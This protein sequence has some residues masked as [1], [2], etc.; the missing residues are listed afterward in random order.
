MISVP[1]E[2]EYVEFGTLIPDIPLPEKCQKECS[3]I[4]KNPVQPSSTRRTNNE[5]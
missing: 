4:L 1:F 5:M 3:L 2:L